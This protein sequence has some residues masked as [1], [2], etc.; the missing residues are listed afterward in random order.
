MPEGSEVRILQASSQEI[1][2]VQSLW[3]EYWDSLRMPADFQNFAEEIKTL[4]GVYAPPPGRLLIARIQGE[5]AGTAALR[6][7]GA[8]S[9]EAK[10]L[11]V[12]PHYRGKGI[13]VALLERLIEEARAAGYREMFADTLAFMTP[14]LRMYRQFG[15]SEVAPYSANPTP[16][17]IFLRLPLER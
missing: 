17:G 4:P 14:A 11:Y 10:R 15:F 1:D 16:G 12:R 8:Y 2:T 13:G 5:P 9:C 3:R 6:S 7:L